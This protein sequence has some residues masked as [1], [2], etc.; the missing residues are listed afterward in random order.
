MMEQQRRGEVEEERKEREVRGVHG[1]CK[2]HVGV[3]HEM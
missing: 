2:G 1:G 3:R